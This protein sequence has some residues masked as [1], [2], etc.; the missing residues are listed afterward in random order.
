M[1]NAQRII[2]LDPVGEMKTELESRPRTVADDPISARQARRRRGAVAPR[3]K[4]SLSVLS[5]GALLVASLLGTAVA[6]DA[7]PGA[8]H[9]QAAGHTGGTPSTDSPYADRYDPAAPIRALTPEEIGQIER[10]EGAGFA[11]P[12]ELNGVP[13]PSHVLTMADELGLSS[14]QHTQVQAIFDEM[15][16]AVIPAGARYL[17][18]Q[19][20]LEADF[21]ASTLTETDL[22]GRIADVFGREG[23][24]VAA[25]LLAHL[26]T[27]QMLTPAQI[28]D[29]N[30]LRGYE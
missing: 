12:A 16:A 25:H 24:L 4:T 28:A 20:V 5:L 15:R 23:E 8:Q 29:Y 30:R 22:P 27:A 26:Q 6:Q 19:Q 14:V 18:A 11:L 3:L 21:R 2:A 13:G 17:A 1:S 9:D 10:G 7:T